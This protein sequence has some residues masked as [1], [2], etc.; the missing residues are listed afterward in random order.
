MLVKEIASLKQELKSANGRALI[1]SRTMT[2][3]SSSNGARITKDLTTSLS[4]K[5]R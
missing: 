3:R 2:K 5:H 1:K 4:S